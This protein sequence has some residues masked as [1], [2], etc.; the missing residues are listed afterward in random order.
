MRKVISH[1]FL[2]LDGVAQLDHIHGLIMGLLD[3]ELN[4]DTFLK[5]AQEDAMILGRRTYEAWAP[6]WPTS[7]LPFAS[8]INNISKYV[9]SQ[10]SSSFP[11]GNHLPATSLGDLQNG[12]AHLKS[13]P[14][15]NIGVHGSP[16]LVSGLIQQNLLDELRLAIFPIFAGNGS[17]L[18]ANEGLPKQLALVDS[19]TTS[20]GVIIATYQLKP[21]KA[22]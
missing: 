2:S 16:S 17:R 10:T 20:N 4:H 3:E 5:L 11:W 18:F 14:G 21:H 13:L 9:A 8:H 22:D 12:I 15:K 1:L 19:K 6:F 7:T